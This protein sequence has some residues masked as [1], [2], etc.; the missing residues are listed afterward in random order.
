MATALGAMTL[1][2]FVQV[3]LRYVFKSGIVWSLEA[4][5]Y[6]FGLLIVIGM[7]YGVRTH[8]HIAV[9][10]LTRSLRPPLK[11]AVATVAFG[12]SLVYCG[13]M[14]YGSVI[15]VAGLMRLGHYLQDIP[16]PR[17]LL[18]AMLPAGFALLALRLMQ[19]GR[20]YF[21]DAPAPE[22]VDTTGADR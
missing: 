7:A 3:V 16:L 15:Y 22:G 4:T 8:S 11:R 10:I 2:T 20:H 14:A 6:I 1:L 21:E 17:W 12:I 13:L 5:S 19:A 9:D 18:L